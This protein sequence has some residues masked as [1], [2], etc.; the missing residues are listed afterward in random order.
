LRSVYSVVMRFYVQHH[1]QKRYP[2][3]RWNLDDD[4]G[5]CVF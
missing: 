1:S 3:S 5:H 2:M 4:H